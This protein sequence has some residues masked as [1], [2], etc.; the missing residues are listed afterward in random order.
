MNASLRTMPFLPGAASA[1]S[2]FSYPTRFHSSRKALAFLGI[3][4]CLVLSEQAAR[5]QWVQTSLRTPGSVNSIFAS[6][7]NLFVGADDHGI[8]VSRDSGSSWTGVDMLSMDANVHVS[9]FVNRG[10]FYSQGRQGHILQVS[11]VR[12]IM[13]QVGVGKLPRS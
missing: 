2:R 7:A 5:G 4:M 1:R 10:Q 11:I 3:V 13:G 12:P 8:F 6:G 9:T